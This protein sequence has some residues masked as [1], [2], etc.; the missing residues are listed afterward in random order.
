MTLRQA[1]TLQWPLFAGVYFTGPSSTSREICNTPK[2]T[3]RTFQGHQD[4]QKLTRGATS[5][6]H[7][8]IDE[9]KKNVL[10]IQS[11]FPL[12]EPSLS[13]ESSQLATSWSSSLEL[14]RGQLRLWRATL[15]S[16]ITSPAWLESSW[17]KHR[18]TTQTPLLPGT[19][20]FPSELQFAQTWYHWKLD[21]SRFPMEPYMTYFGHQKDPKNCPKKEGKKL[22]EI[23]SRRDKIEEELS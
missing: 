22:S 19:I 10:E 13:I 12:G 16:P 8:K 14:Y 18:K 20:T 11:T 3:S 23:S 7:G 15:G 9:S 4:H 21:L 17:E 2:K 6:V 1:K 5:T